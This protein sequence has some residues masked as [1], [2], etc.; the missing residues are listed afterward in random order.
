VTYLREIHPTNLM[1]SL[2]QITINLFECSSA[3][4]HLTI[5]GTGSRFFPSSHQR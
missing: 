4:Y 5:S 1:L 3:R 2:I